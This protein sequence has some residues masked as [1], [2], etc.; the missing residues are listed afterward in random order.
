[1]MIFFPSVL[2]YNCECQVFI[3]FIF[4][5]LNQQPYNNTHI[6]GMPKTIYKLWWWLILY[7]SWSSTIFFLISQ[8]FSSL[9][10]NDHHCHSI[11]ISHQTVQNRRPNFFLLIMIIIIIIDSE[12]LSPHEYIVKWLNPFLVPNKHHI[13]YIQSSYKK[14]YT[15]TTRNIA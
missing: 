7:F 14:Q 12:R 8:Q 11:L 3:I 10:W 5:K 4:Y 1:M 2:Y 6:Q 9:S 13:T 15:E